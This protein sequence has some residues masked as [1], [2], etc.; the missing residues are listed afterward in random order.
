MNMAMADVSQVMENFEKVRLGSD[1]CVGLA[2]LM[3]TS[4]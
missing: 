3:T 1:K 4:I 2:K